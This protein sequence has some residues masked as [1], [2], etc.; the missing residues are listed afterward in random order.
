MSTQVFSGDFNVSLYETVSH[1]TLITPFES[2]K[3]QRRQKWRKA[4]RSFK[5][6]LRGKSATDT[7]EKWKFYTE[8][9]G[10]YDSFYFEN[11]HESPTSLSGDEVLGTGDGIDTSWQFN[12]YPVISGDCDITVGA[13]G[14]SEAVDYTVNYTTGAITMVTVPP[15]G[16]VITATDYRFFRICRFVEDNLTR[17]LFSYKLYNMGL[18]LIEI[19]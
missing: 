19:L 8:R 11:T 13:S 15:S 9:H 2:G 10:A 7:Q 4:R 14:Y 3:E 1:R 18:E 17:E 16:D 6:D 5:L 12:R